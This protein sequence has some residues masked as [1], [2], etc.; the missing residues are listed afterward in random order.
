MNHGMINFD[1][2][3]NVVQN[4]SRCDR[5]LH[6]EVVVAGKVCVQ[7]E[8]FDFVVLRIEQNILKLALMKISFIKECMTTFCST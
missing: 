3:S 5:F 8:F 2:P 7:N 1:T 6:V 4:I